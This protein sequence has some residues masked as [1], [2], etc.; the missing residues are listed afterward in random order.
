M[1]VIQPPSLRMSGE[2]KDLKIDSVFSLNGKIV[3]RIKEVCNGISFFSSEI[4]RERDGNVGIVI[5]Q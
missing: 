1:D 2:E 4:D 3:W 5:Q